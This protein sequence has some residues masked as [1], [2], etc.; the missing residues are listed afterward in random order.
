ME[1]KPKD[2]CHVAHLVHEHLTSYDEPYNYRETLEYFFCDA[3]GG[4]SFDGASA[5]RRSLMYVHY[6]KMSEFLEA[7][8]KMK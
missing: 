4:V 6:K 5:Q 2:H 8:E 7:L 1:C 3:I